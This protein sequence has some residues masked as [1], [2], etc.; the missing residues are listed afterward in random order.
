MQDF[1]NFVG[2][3]NYNI[4]P[5]ALGMCIV[6]YLKKLPYNEAVN[7][8][9]YLYGKEDIVQYNLP[10]ILVTVSDLASNQTGFLQHMDVR[11]EVLRNKMVQNRTAE[12]FQN[13]MAMERTV[14]SITNTSDF[15]TV[16][17]RDLPYLNFIGEKYRARYL[18]DNSGVEVSFR[19]SYLFTYYKK[20]ID[21]GNYYPTGE[22][23][24]IFTP[25]EV[26]T[27]ATYGGLSLDGK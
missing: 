20:Y 23:K 9:I 24:E 8:S 17:S 13:Q 10:A 22:Y 21:M 25:T 16:V 7:Y 3:M 27:I 1:E 14:Q 19:A 18:S 6:N 4:P 15:L 11:I 5:L 2:E 26:K 12:F